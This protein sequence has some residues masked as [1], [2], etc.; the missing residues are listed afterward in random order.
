MLNPCDKSF[1]SSIQFIFLYSL[2][3]PWPPLEGQYLKLGCCIGLFSSKLH[4]S[5]ISKAQYLNLYLVFS[6]PGQVWSGWVI[7]KWVKFSLGSIVV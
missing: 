3:H 1:F 6:N 5:L 4:N 2:T 7:V